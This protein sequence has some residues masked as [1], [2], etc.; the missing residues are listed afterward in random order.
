MRNGMKRRKRWLVP[1]ETCD[2]CHKSIT[3]VFIDGAT[4]Y[5]PWAIMCLNCF[6]EVGTTL[7]TGRGQ[8]YWKDK[9][10]HF[11]KIEG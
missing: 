3:N 5:G 6:Q 4:K 2:I 1:P 10:G 9:D 11:Y 7:G 8:E